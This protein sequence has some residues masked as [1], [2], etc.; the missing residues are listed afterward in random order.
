MGIICTKAARI[1]NQQVLDLI[2]RVWPYG[3]SIQGT[4]FTM[5]EI[6][7]FALPQGMADLVKGEL[8]QLLADNKEMGEMER[9]SVY[10]DKT[11]RKTA[12]LIAHSC[13]AVIRKE[14][15]F[16]VLILFV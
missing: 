5:A 14:I 6:I 11:F 16:H 9:F 12:S 10:I 2:F 7:I 13:Q 1:G 8:I 4:V 15:V 3:E